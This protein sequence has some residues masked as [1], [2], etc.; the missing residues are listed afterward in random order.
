MNED[1]DAHV[2]QVLTDFSHISFALLFGSLATGRQHAGSDLDLAVAADKAL[3]ADQRMALINA[4]AA[5]C[6]RPVDLVD[7][8]TVTEPLL[9]QILRYGR[10][11]LGSDTMYGR[12]ISHHLFEQADFMPYRNRV[13]AERRQRWIGK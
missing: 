11:V 9:G 5:R 12:L 8:K 2:R 13:L 6:G 7:L 10:R 4:L 1:I 3:S